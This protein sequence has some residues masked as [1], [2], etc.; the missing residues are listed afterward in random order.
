[1]IK[2]HFTRKPD[3]RSGIKEM[4]INDE[5]RTVSFKIDR[6]SNDIE[7]DI[8]QS[9]I[10][11]ARLLGLEPVVELPDAPNQLEEGTT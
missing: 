5:D 1:M 7:R 2:H 11:L 10:L 8:M 9:G 6:Y 3:S 4:V